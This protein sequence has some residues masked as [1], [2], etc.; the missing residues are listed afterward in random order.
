MVD[1]TALATLAELV[2]HNPAAVAEIVDAFVVDTPELLREIRLGCA[3][4]A[5]EQVAAAAHP[6]VSSSATVGARSLSSQAAALERVARAGQLPSAAALAI[7]SA[8]A[9]HSLGHL[10]QWLAAQFRPLPAVGQPR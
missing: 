2:G 9:E 10:R 8:T 6:L 1:E 3:R 7:L 4:G 5:P